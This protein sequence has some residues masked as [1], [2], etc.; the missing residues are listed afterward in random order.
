LGEEFIKYLR[1]YLAD[2]EKIEP[3]LISVEAA[4]TFFPVTEPLTPR[5]DST[6]KGTA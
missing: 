6:G 4:Q 3:N 1:R 2:T 5:N